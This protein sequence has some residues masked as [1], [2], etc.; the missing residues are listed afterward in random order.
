MPENLAVSLECGV[1]VCV[2]NFTWR[3]RLGCPASRA[4]HPQSQGQARCRKCSK[5]KA[6]WAGPPAHSRAL[7]AL[8]RSQK[9]LLSRADSALER[10]SPRVPVTPSRSSGTSSGVITDLA[11]CPPSPGVRCPRGDGPLCL[12]PLCGLAVS[13]SRTSL[14]QVPP[15]STWSTLRS[16]AGAE[17]LRRRR[18]CVPLISVR[19]RDVLVPLSRC[20]SRAGLDIASLCPCSVPLFPAVR[21]QAA[22]T[23]PALSPPPVPPVCQPCLLF[24]FSCVLELGVDIG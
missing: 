17:H 10:F 6:G 21:T 15:L 13:L 5:R 2:V 19:G 9:T 18:P 20:G 11:R 4:M 3:M 8:R 7:G 22:R 16:P 24:L 23:R 14:G 1:F 12:R